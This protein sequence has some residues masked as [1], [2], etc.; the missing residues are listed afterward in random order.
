MKNKVIIV[1]IALEM[2]M[3]GFNPEMI[4]PILYFCALYT[5][6]LVPCCIAIAVF[7]AVLF[8]K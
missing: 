5:A 8:R 6:V 4:K 7:A 3:L 2:V 1:L